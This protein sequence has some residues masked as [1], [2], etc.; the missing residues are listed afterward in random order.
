MVEEEGRS[1]RVGT[2]ELWA[3]FVEVGVKSSDDAVWQ[4]DWTDDKG[5]AALS[6]E[7]K[8]QSVYNDTRMMFF[9][10]TENRIVLRCRVLERDKIAISNAAVELHPA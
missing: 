5:G 10:Q 9:V 1:W 6:Q 4:I 8:E 2:Q 7:Y 3:A